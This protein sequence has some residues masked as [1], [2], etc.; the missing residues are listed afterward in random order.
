MS[1]ANTAYNFVVGSQ[2]LSFK[3]QKGTI[4]DAF[5][6]SSLGATKF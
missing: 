5:S 2:I 6:Y 3:M 4:A 1:F